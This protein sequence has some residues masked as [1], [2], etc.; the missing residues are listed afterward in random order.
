MMS[1]MMKEVPIRRHETL[2]RRFIIIGTIE[3]IDLGVFR[4]DPSRL[5]Q[6]VDA[7][8]RISVYEK[9]VRASRYGRKPVA[10]GCRPLPGLTNERACHLNSVEVVHRN[11]P[12]AAVVTDKDFGIRQVLIAKT[13]QA[14]LEIR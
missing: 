9:Q 7:W 10:S 11:R 5:F 12:C 6:H 8:D 14:S 4:N 13:C 2:V 3:R 1:V